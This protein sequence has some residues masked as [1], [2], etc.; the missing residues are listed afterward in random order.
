MLYLVDASIYVFRAWFS[1]D[2]SITDKQGR[3]VNAVYG[4]AIF[5]AQLLQQA[6]P[7]HISILFDESLT[8]SFRNRI[9]PPYKANR[10][11]A[12]DELKYQ[13]KCCQQLCKAAGIHTMSS[14]RYEAD[15][16]IGSM[17]Q[18]FR[19]QSQGVVIVSRD[20][21]L[22][23]LIQNNDYMWDFADDC[24]YDSKQ[25]ELHFGVRPDQIIDYLALA[26]DAVDN[27]PGVRGVGKKTAQTLL[28][29]YASLDAL[30]DDLDAVLDLPIRGVKRIH[31][32]LDEQ[33]DMAYLSQ[34]LTRIKCDVKLT[35]NR[36]DLRWQPDIK[37]LERFF[38]RLGTG[39]RLLKRFEQ[40]IG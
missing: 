8:S 30:Y 10:D 25:A 13:F 4:F 21:D 17:A 15:D 33:R 19:K 18:R 32:L 16:L 20:K 38:N 35:V 14:K 28:Q 39:Q 34:Q 29:H 5:L 26:G 31:R 36:K 40:A 11:P 24:Q 23:Q 6:Q 1:M 3:P 9:Y 12:P 2:D 37:K 22:V 7:R 27:I